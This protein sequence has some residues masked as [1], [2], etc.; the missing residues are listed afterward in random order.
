MVC[1]Y[2]SERCSK[3]FGV[4]VQVWSL[5]AS[6]SGAWT[7]EHEDLAQHALHNVTRL[8][9]AVIQSDESVVTQLN[10]SQVSI[11]SSKKQQ[12]FYSC[13]VSV[14]LSRSCLCSSFRCEP[15]S[16]H[17]IKW[18]RMARLERVFPRV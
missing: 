9:A 15:F 1:E 6:H 14:L 4:I 10:Q 7:A 13:E 16:L 11:L 17:G 5:A 3:Q 12:A 2:F 18:H 8:C